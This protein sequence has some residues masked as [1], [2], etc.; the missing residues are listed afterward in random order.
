M[1]QYYRN[2]ETGL[3]MKPAKHFF[4]LSFA[5]YAFSHQSHNEFVQR[6][7]E[8]RFQAD[9]IG[10]LFPFLEACKVVRQ[11]ATELQNPF[12]ENFHLLRFHIG[13]FHTHSHAS[14]GRSNDSLRYERPFILREPHLHQGPHGKRAGRVDEAT[15]SA[16]IAGPRRAQC[17]RTQIENLRRR[18][19]LISR[20]DASFFSRS[21]VRPVGSLL[22]AGAFRRVSLHGTRETFL[23]D[24]F[25]LFVAFQRHRLI[26]PWPSGTPRIRGMQSCCHILAQLVR[27]RAPNR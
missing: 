3:E 23:R 9:L 25:Q 16:D 21:S 15:P 22:R 11:A 6:V 12:F 8:F 5:H 4:S 19:Q 26:H 1:W 7:V 10:G 27:R 20:M 2:P 14:H 18:R 13:E 17:S 24:L